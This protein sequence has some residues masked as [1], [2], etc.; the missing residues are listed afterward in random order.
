MAMK[1]T[2]GS[3]YVRFDFEKWYI[4]KAQGEILSGGGF[5]VYKSSMTHREP[6]HEKEEI[7]PKH[8]E[9]IICE[10]QKITNKDTVQLIFE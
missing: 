5:V 8:L 4:A 3:S 1:I 6:P 10:V 2:G 9:E 7:T